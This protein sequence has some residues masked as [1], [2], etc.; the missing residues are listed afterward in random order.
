[1]YR[2]I[3][4]YLTIKES[5]IEGLGL[6]TNE[7]IVDEITI[8]MT[9]VYRNWPPIEESELIRTPLGGFINH[10]D[11]PNCELL[12]LVGEKHLKTIRDIQAGEELTVKY[13]LYSVSSS[14][15]STS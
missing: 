5:D 10:S 4:D 3:P 1:M 14:S 7:V 6:F 13:K 12:D 9:H 15:I 8:G 11:D 2:P